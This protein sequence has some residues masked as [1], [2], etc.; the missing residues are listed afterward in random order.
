MFLI[1]GRGMEKIIWLQTFN[2]DIDIVD[3]QHKILVERLN[4]L[5]DLHINGYTEEQLYTLLNHLED[6]THF[7]FDTEEKYFKYFKYTEL[8][9]HIAEHNFFKE[10]IKNLK[11]G[12]KENQAHLDEELLLFLSSWLLDHILGTDKRFAQE[13]NNEISKRSNNID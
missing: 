12:I 10:K 1:G 13:F 6:Y 11:I 2:T 9:E 7:H 5:I 3:F 4:E 8:N